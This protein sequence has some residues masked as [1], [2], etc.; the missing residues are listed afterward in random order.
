MGLILSDNKKEMNKLKNYLLPVV[1]FVL[2]LGCVSLYPQITFGFSGK[3]T[4][5]PVDNE[6]GARRNVF[7]HTIEENDTIEDAVE[8]RNCSNETIT[9]FV[10]S[11]GSE[12][13]DGK[14]VEANVPDDKRDEP[15]TW[16][17]FEQQEFVLSPRTTK[18]VNFKINVPSKVDV[19]DHQT[20]LYVQGVEPKSNINRGGLNITIR[21]GITIYMTMPGEIDRTL[22][23]EKINHRI[24]PFW[25][26]FAKEMFF[27]VKF[28]NE[29]NITLRPVA[30]I[31]MK[32]F[33]GLVGSMEDIEYAKIR[34]ED[35]V[36]A[37]KQWIKR[38][39][40][41]GRFVV[42][43]DFHLG[44]K[45]QLNEDGTTTLLPDEVIHA[46]Y[47][48]WVFPWIEI[49][50]LIGIFF[51]LYLI[52]S[53]WLYA[54]ISRRLR[55]KSK[56]YKIVKNDT[57]TGIA[58]KFGVDP[59]VLAKFNMMRWP[60]EV[61]PGDKLLIPVGRMEHEEWEKQSRI[62]LGDR[63][64]VGGILG[65]LFHRRG[66]HHITRRL[67]SQDEKELDK[68]VEILI[69]E[70]GD[71]ITDVADFAGVS[72]Q[73][74]IDMNNLRPPYRLR[75]GRELVVPKPAPKKPKKKSKK[76]RKKRKGK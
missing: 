11:G 61:K 63:E 14:L 5:E 25:K 72:L 56:V 13:V 68:N 59:R 12:V 30:D 70:P 66:V 20:I 34:R 47:V 49:V 53:M 17:E 67:M 62:M 28:R 40:Y 1:V 3:V 15:G 6:Y 52:R 69:V 48:F 43:F 75:T 64:I 38:A 10:F 65:H 36:E 76:T 37:E 54:V 46:K 26:L 42:D 60:Y 71:T 50:Y 8:I 4:A 35:S 39:P 16:L 22:V 33:F 24:S 73:T 7:I 58:A 23:I 55:T 21:N 2:I 27:N 9:A 44:E 19:G 32:G 74:V 31:E 18:I 29:G 57:L 51:I 45:E 41:F